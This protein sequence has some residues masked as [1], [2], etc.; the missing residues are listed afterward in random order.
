MRPRPCHCHLLARDQTALP[1][2]L[3]LLQGPRLA[4][5]PSGQAPQFTLVRPA[6]IHWRRVPGRA[7]PEPGSSMVLSP[8]GQHGGF[9][10][11]GIS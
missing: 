7:P 1:G 2:A 5:R 10:V 6:L 4:G 9:C 3:I 8:Y 11:T